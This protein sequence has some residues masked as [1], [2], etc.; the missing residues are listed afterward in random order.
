[1]EGHIRTR[2]RTST[3]EWSPPIFVPGNDITVSG[4][5]PGLNYGQQC[6]EGM[7]AFRTVDGRIVVFRP[8]FHAA[9]MRRSA[10]SVLLCPPNEEI[11]LDCV[12]RA[13]LA[14]AEHVPAYGSG[15]F[16][17]IRPVM[18]GSS[19]ALWGI[20][21]E[22]IFAV[23]AVLVKPPQSPVSAIVCDEFD[24]CAPR[25]MGSYKVGGNY[26]PVSIRHSSA[27]RANTCSH[28]T[29]L[30]MII[31]LEIRWQSSSDGPWSSVAS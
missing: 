27:S 19:S 14:N 8:Q 25:G 24:R 13:V 29:E 10:E 20:C 28:R 17:Y 9:R 7:K 23:F 26:A 12:R 3:K 5:S 21:D 15:A 6:F 2:Y 30:T 4:L 16:L 18:F 1:M 31:D 11:F 22:S